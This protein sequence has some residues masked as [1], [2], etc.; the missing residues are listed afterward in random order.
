MNV[1]Y[2]PE[3]PQDIKRYEAQYR[4]VSPKLGLRFR[5][6]VDKAIEH[7]KASPSSGGHFL[8]TGS[9]I[10]KEVRRR[11]LSSFPFFVLYGVSG[12][13]LIFRSLIPSSSDPL[14]WLKRLPLKG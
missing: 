3:F 11:N 1:S 2:H 7:I 6:E 9:K 4:E 8:N 14:T 5:A 12:D 13:T 10:V